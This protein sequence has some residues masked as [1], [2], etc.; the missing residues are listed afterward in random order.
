MQCIIQSV[1]ENRKLCEKTTFTHWFV[2]EAEIIYTLDAIMGKLFQL[3]LKM[4]FMNANLILLETEEIH[5]KV[6]RALLLIVTINIYIILTSFKYCWKVFSLLYLTAVVDYKHRYNDR[7]VLQNILHWI[8]LHV[9][10]TMFQTFVW[11]NWIFLKCN[12]ILGL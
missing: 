1:C 5:F 11:G 3:V 6:I 7:R 8:I 2:G 10:L 4:L 12:W 9:E